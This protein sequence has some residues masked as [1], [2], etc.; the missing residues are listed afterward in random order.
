MVCSPENELWVS[1]LE[2]AYAKLHCSYE[3][4]VGG[5]V[6][7]GLVDLSGGAADELCVYGGTL[8]P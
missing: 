4:L 2:K 5:L 8:R 1:I 3:A 7:V 6:H